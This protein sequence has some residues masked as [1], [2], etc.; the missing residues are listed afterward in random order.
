MTSVAAADYSP[1]SRPECPASTTRAG[2][3]ACLRGSSGAYRPESDCRHFDGTSAL[4][5]GCVCLLR[6]AVNH[7]RANACE[8]PRRQ[9]HWSCICA[10]RTGRSE[11]A[12]IFSGKEKA[13]RKVLLM[14]AT[15]ALLGAGALVGTAQA[16]HGRYGGYY[17]GYGGYG[18]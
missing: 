18:G 4:I 11:P 13:M 5:D 12:R 8:P 6:L 14:L 15:F 17:R 7:S 16:D 1:R 10:C 3:S 2:L 9:R